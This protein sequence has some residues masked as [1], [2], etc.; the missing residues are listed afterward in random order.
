MDMGWWLGEIKGERAEIM[1]LNT[2]R[3]RKRG[4]DDGTAFYSNG[5]DLL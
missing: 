3:M 1:E 2:P 4:R 5:M